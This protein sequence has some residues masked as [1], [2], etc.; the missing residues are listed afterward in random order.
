M[1]RI[2]LIAEPGATLS[3]VMITLDMVNIASR[4]PEAAACRL[5]LL[6]TGGGTVALSPIIRIETQTLPESLAGYDAIILPG[7]FAADVGDL[8]AKLASVWQ[9]VI[10]CLRGLPPDT[11]VSASCYG[12]FVLAESGLLDAARATT[13]WWLESEFH[14]H[15]PAVRLEAERALVDG[16]RCITA[17]AMTAH[18]DLALHVLRRLFGAALARQVGGIMLVD[19]ARTSQRP[20][21]TLPIRFEDALVQDAVN[22][23]MAR[24]TGEIGTQE[25]A[26]AMH[27]SYR[28]LHRRFQ[29]A[30]GMAP[31]AY[32]QALR[33]EKAKELLE[34]TRRS[35]EQIVGEIGYQDVSAFRRLFARST[36]LSPAQY[37]LRFR[38]PAGEE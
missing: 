35:L 30:A 6:S 23:L 12:T 36:G 2:A 8:H 18:A 1:S 11:L 10:G 25:L 17:G 26:A 27:V 3:S 24:S 21:M 13:T 31:L 14:R 7:F 4:Y 38:R 29:A 5:D 32:L 28:T 37:R 34:S 16:G 9:P 15:Y 33:V 19:G 22:W 20:F